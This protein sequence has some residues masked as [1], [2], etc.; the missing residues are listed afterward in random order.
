MDADEKSLKELV[1]LTSA[2]F[3]GLV[4]AYGRVFIHG[5]IFGLGLDSRFSIKDWLPHHQGTTNIPFPWFLLL[6]LNRQTKKSDSENGRFLGIS[7]CVHASS[8]SKRK[9]KG[10][11]AMNNRSVH[12][13]PLP[14]STEPSFSSLFW[15]L[16]SGKH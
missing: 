12:W 1:M 13:I 11:L 9:G 8:S 4:Q 3:I 16:G 6:G 15:D 10:K 5:L 14:I 2:I 7:L